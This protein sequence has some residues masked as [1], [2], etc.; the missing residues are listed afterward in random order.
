MLEKILTLIFGSKHE[1]DIKR[2]RPIVAE[3]NEYYQQFHELSDDA[4]RYK[5]I[6]FKRRIQERVSDIQDQIYDLQQQLREDVDS[7]VPIDT[8]RIRE[9]IKALEKEEKEAIDEV[10]LELMPEAFAVVKEACR[11]LVGHSWSVSDIPITWDMVPFDV[12][13]IGAVVLHE[14]KIAEM[15]TGEGKTLVASLPLYLNA[16]VGKGAH[17]V[18]VNDY[19]ARRDCEWM[20]KIYETLGLAPAFI[21]NDMNPSQRQKAYNADITYGTNNEFGFDYLRDNMA[22]RVEDVVQRGHYY[23]IIDEVDSVLIDEARTPLIISGPVEHSTQRFDE[24]KPRVAQLVRSQTNLVNKLIAEAEHLLEQGEE[25]EAGKKLL[26]ANRGAPKNKRLIKVLHEPGAKKLIHRVEMDYLRDK[27]LHE[28]DEE[29]YYSIDE[30]THVIDLTE[31]GREAL[32]PNDPSMFVLP[33]LATELE[34]IDK[35]PNLDEAAKQEAKSRVQAEYAEK[36]ERIHNITQL[37]RAYS[38]YER[39]VE[40]VVTEDG[41]VV[42]VDEFTGRLMPGR[43]YSDG[44]HQAIE[45]K[46]G[47]RIERETQTLATITLQNFFRLY[48]KLAGMTGT[49]ETEAHEFW[50]IYKLDVVVIPTNEPVRRIDYNDQI[51]R[52]KR[53]KYNAVIAEIEEMH[54]KNRPVLV[55]TIS[56]EVSET[57]SRMLKRKG[58][59]HSVLNAKYHKEEAQIVA[60][61]GQPGMVT[62]ATNMAGRGTDIKLGKGVVLCDGGC[63][64]VDDN[65]RPIPK[66]LDLSQCEADVPCGLHIIGTERHESRRIDRQLRGRSGRQ[67]DPGSSRFYLSL[68]DDLMRLF[69]SERIASVMDRLGVQD[70]EVIQH[71]MINKSIERA[72]KRVEMHNFE[73]RKHLLEYDDVMNQ[74]REVIYK[75]RSNALRGENLRDVILDMIDQ[76]VEDRVELHVGDQKYVEDW[77]WAGLNKDLQRFFLLS[78]MYHDGSEVPPGL[79]KELL[80][81]QIK[82]KAR[83]NYALRERTIGKA[84][85]RKLERLVMLQQ[86]DIEWRDHLYEMDQLKEGIGLRAYG[87]KDPLIEYKSEGFRAF[88]DMLARINEGVVELIFKAQIRDQSQFVPRR[89]P[90]VLSEVHDS[91]AGMG[92]RTAAA[93]ASAAGQQTLPQQPAPGKKVPVVV[94]P[95]VGR[96]DPCPCGSGKKYKK[97][98]GR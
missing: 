63:Y 53:E 52:T 30:K 46:E 3:I 54:R 17:L 24:V 6:E 66:D 83:A 57:L 7:D 34:Q 86:I 40:Y 90:R 87:Q 37:L 95:K 74:Q 79:T 36:S 58:I 70:G 45:A 50:Q 51:Y 76:I 94:G 49:A 80:I 42:I 72:Q 11:R 21:T 89:R 19:L 67:G 41:K 32:S 15:A 1:R 39:D 8:E 33:D 43:R 93:T 92:F 82:E 73:I 38:L 75:M 97:C 4:L 27:R 85:M 88:T 23:A 48:Q 25:Y 61:A 55:G 18:T 64:L 20:G 47:V 69:G 29:L 26:Q 35:D 77:N 10:L 56:V 78:P 13:L 22:I 59:K 68:E 14:G 12:Q 5:T 16:L 81:E 84:N 62:I 65:G 91:S 2:I 44:L 60:K 28:L 9:E 96:N 31:K 71:P 98:H